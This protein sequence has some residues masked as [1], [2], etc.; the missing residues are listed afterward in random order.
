MI[1]LPQNVFGLMKSKWRIP[2]S[3]GRTWTG[4]GIRAAGRNPSLHQLLSWSLEYFYFTATGRCLRRGI[5]FPVIASVWFRCPWNGAAHRSVRPAGFVHA[6]ENRKSPFL[7]RFEQKGE[8]L[9]QLS[10]FYP[11]CDE[12]STWRRC[13]CDEPKMFLQFS[14]QRAFG[15]GCLSAPDS[16]AHRSSLNTEQ[17][18]SGSKAS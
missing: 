8:D 15:S 6:A 9:N 5:T 18:T 3:P 12:C 2:V 4:R 10:G 7:W 11:F 17:M 14:W 1:N 13:G 16:R